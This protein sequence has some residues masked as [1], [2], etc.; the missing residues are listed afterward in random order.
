MRSSVL[1]LL[2]LYI[3]PE[4]IV[5][6]LIGNLIG[7]GLAIL[8]FFLIPIA[9]L[10][11]TKAFSNI[12]I[13][14][15]DVLDKN[16]NSYHLIT[17]GGKYFW[18]GNRITYETAVK[19]NQAKLRLLSILFFIKVIFIIPGYAT[20]L[21]GLLMLIFMIPYLAIGKYFK[22]NVAGIIYEVDPESGE[23]RKAEIYDIDIKQPV[24]FF[25][26]VFNKVFNNNQDL[27]SFTA[28]ARGKKST[29][30]QGNAN[31]FGQ[32][33]SNPFGQSSSDTNNQNNSNSQAS[34]RPQTPSEHISKEHSSIDKVKK[35]EFVD[36]SIVN[37]D[38]SEK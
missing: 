17:T 21:V 29:F 26:S 11:L 34:N 33:S 16:N 23:S 4:I 2:L 12:V 15:Y 32:T 24:F 31:P 20:Y 9:G 19:I 10:Y 28:F 14:K 30:N 35:G 25:K 7:Y 1:S 22:R 3:V 5:F 27:D 38:K 18:S 6:I 37:E 13:K 36:A 8:G